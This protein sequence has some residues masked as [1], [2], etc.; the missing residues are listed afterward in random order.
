MGSAS[1]VV[2]VALGILAVGC[3]DVDSGEDPSSK[4]ISV[5]CVDVVG[6]IVSGHKQ[7]KKR[8]VARPVVALLV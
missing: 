5:A 6:T 2:C 7:R 4:V 3:A 8:P 1:D